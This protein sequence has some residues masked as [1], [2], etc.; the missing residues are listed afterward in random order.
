MH[1]I[2]A[3]R[4]AQRVCHCTGDRDGIFDRELLF[5][6]EAVTQRLARHVRHDVVEQAVRLSRVVQREDVGMTEARGGF[7]LPEKPLPPEG[8][9]E[10]RRQHLDGHRA[11]VLQVLSEIDRGHSPAPELALD[12]VTA[13]EG[14]LNVGEEVGHRGAFVCVTTPS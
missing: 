14:G 12:R 8:G 5:P 4:I 3:V 1:D 7:D 9:R 13:G 10:L 11:T 6:I 2:V